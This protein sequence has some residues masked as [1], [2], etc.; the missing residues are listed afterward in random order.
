[1][2][3]TLVS[4][5]NGVIEIDMQAGD[6]VQVTDKTRKAVCPGPQEYTRNTDFFYG[7]IRR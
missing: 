6:V 7:D 5:E 1:M 3:F 4:E 2:P